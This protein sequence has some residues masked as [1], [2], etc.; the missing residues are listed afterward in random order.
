MVVFLRCHRDQFDIIFIYSTKN[1]VE[2]YC[3]VGTKKKRGLGNE[4]TI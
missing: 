3:T 1:G 2:E 4:L